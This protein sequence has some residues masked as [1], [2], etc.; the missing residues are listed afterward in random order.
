MPSIVPWV[1][2]PFFAPTMIRHFKSDLR[3]LSLTECWNLTRNWTVLLLLGA[4]AFRIPWFS[5]TGVPMS[6]HV[7]EFLG[8]MDDLDE[9]QR[10]AVLGHLGELEPLGFHSPVVLVPKDNLLVGIHTGIVLL[11]HGSGRHLARITV[12]KV[13]LAGTPKR[14]SW[15]GFGTF[16]A[17]GTQIYSSG[18]RRL[19]DPLPGD[20]GLYRPGMRSAAL[21]A[22]HQDLVAKRLAGRIPRPV[23]TE[24]EFWQVQS[25]LEDRVF[26]HH[27]ATG[28]YQ[29][30]TE[31]E[32]A[33]QR[34]LVAKATGAPTS[35]G[36]GTEAAVDHRTVD[37]PDAPVL[38]ALEKEQSKKSGNSAVAW[39]IFAI[40]LALFV[41]S[42]IR[43][44]DPKYLVLLVGVLLLHELGHF[45]AMK[46]FG[47]RDLKMFFIPFFGAAV[48]GK[49]LRVPV[50][51]EVLI[52][53]AGPVPGML[54]GAYLYHRG[55]GL[56]EGWVHRFANLLLGLNAFNLIPVSPLDGGRILNAVLF[57]RNRWIESAFQAVA[58]SAL[59]LFAL[60]AGG[61]TLGLGFVGYMMLSG[62][63]HQLRIG[64]VI[65]GLRQDG[66]V[67][68][69]TA[70]S[71]ISEGMA[72]AIL[73]RLRAALPEARH[74]AFL[75]AQ[76]I[77]TVYERLHAGRPGWIQT[78]ALLS[79][80]V[81]ALCIPV[82]PLVFSAGGML[83]RLE[84]DS[85][86]QAEAS[87]PRVPLACPDRWGT[88]PTEPAA[89]SVAP[90]TTVVAT[91]TNS[92]PRPDWFQSWPSNRAA[93]TT[94]TRLGASVVVE[95]G[96]ESS[97]WTDGLLAEG[98]LRGLE[99]VHGDT[100]SNRPVLLSLSWKVQDG[101]ARTNLHRVL[102]EYARVASAFPVVPPWDPSWITNVTERPGWS[103]ARADWIRAASLDQLAASPGSSA[104]LEELKQA[105]KSGD[106]N[107]VRKLVAESAKQR[108]EALRGRLET[109]T[110]RAEEPLSPEVA[111][112]Y[113]EYRRIWEPLADAPS[114]PEA[115]KE[116]ERTV[117]RR[118][119][120]LF[121][122]RPSTD[123]PGG[124][125]GK[126]LGISGY[127]Y[128]SEDG[129]LFWSGEPAR[130]VHSFPV[131]ARFLCD[132]GA[133]DLRYRFHVADPSDIFD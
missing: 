26:R 24:E 46:A 115:R 86:L 102:T 15:V 110:R 42:M 73:K 71:G 10:E 83:A 61:A 30:L 8:S 56:G 128:L 70:T 66:T 104:T 121:G 116:R 48:S 79:V 4:K 62:V 88:S 65:E 81:A 14:E 31:A 37:D 89:E 95:G 76:D 68:D 111:E 49:K 6:D 94:V 3:K 82:W 133:T 126:D 69:T 130:L 53:L 41:P 105:R 98:R 28:H 87:E 36:A 109:A 1:P 35:D 22:L 58:G 9:A 47:Y 131:L 123:T 103:R 99:V 12:T 112:A 119:A 93:G 114:T 74:K 25:S 52:L 34:R 84:A 13:N 106:T 63:R 5:A 100:A 97:A 96:P 124:D 91:W 50:W 101:T 32:V 43:D 117:R 78:G 60:K 129:T 125:V 120:A 59:I 45:L 107:R 122:R 80:Y 38:A 108:M 77:R 118:W 90:R 27:L 127:G 113:L 51:Q 29:L 75:L 11:R 54:L 19:M 132:Q 33:E 23:G 39:L 2:H 67:L 40:S 16:P 72:R 18:Y 44:R 57:R 64:K 7:R 20:V 17:D 21:W 55:A 92:T 85:E